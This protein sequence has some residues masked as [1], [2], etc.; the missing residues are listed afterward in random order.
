L[1]VHAGGKGIFRDEITNV[2]GERNLIFEDS[3][4]VVGMRANEEIRRN[5][6][7][8]LVYKLLS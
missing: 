7:E 6:T 4:V 3:R 8:W 1:Q 5:Q 2:V